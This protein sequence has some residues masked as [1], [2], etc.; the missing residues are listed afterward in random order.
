M[1]I[2]QRFQQFVKSGVSAPAHFVRLHGA[3]RML[4][5][6][7]RM[8]RRAE[9]FSL[10]FCQRLKSVCNDRHRQPAPFL[11]LYAVVDTPRRA[12]ASVPKAAD[13]E[14][15]FRC[16]LFN[17]LFRS[18]LLRGELPAANDAGDVVRLL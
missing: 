11:K 14:I 12:G 4:H 8:I 17:V 7:Q 9:S 16:K 6:H 18:P 10:R 1:R 3:D 13:D 2:Y 15:G 5:D